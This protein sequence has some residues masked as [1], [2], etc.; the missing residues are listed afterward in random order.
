MLTID[1]DLLD[2]G[3]GM[4]VLDLGCGEG[5]HAFEAYRRGASVIALDWGQAEVATTW[6][7]L[8]A[9]GAAGEAPAGARAGVVRGDLLALPVP[10]ASV[11]RVIAS[12]VLEHIPDDQRAMAEIERVLKPGGRVAVSVP[13]YGPERVC[14]ALSDSYH[15]NEGGHIRIYRATEVRERLATAGLVPSDSHHAHALHA[16]FWWLKCAVGVERDNAAV[17]AYHR[18]L[19]WDLTHRPWLTRTAERLLDPVIG[20]SLVVYADKPPAPATVTPLA[21]AGRTPVAAD[22]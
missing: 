20:K 11:D 5:R 12:E 13:R 18:L 3:P 16:P 9:I 4:T 1:Y 10:D 15:A 8:G 19:V 22:A 17:R 21:R 6:A 2:L 14:W 7:W